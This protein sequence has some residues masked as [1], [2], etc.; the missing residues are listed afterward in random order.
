[1]SNSVQRNTTIIEDFRGM[2]QY[3]TLANP[4]N[5]KFAETGQNFRINKGAVERINSPKKY[6]VVGTPPASD[7]I[8]DFKCKLNGTSYRLIGIG[9]NLYNFDGTNL[10]T[11]YTSL[12]AT[13]LLDFCI[14]N[15]LIIICQDGKKVLQ[16]DGI[17]CQQVSFTDPG[18]IW[19]DARPLCAK[20]HAN[21]LYYFDK[22][23]KC[24][25]PAPG[26]H[27]DFDNT[28]G[29]VD[30]FVIASGMGDQLVGALPYIGEL[31]II[32]FENSVY[33]LK[34]SQPYSNTAADPHIVQLISNEIGC[35]AK[36]T[37]LEVG[38]DHHWISKNGPVTLQA[39]TAYGDVHASELGYGIQDDIKL[40][41]TNAYASKTFSFYEK[42]TGKVYF[43]FRN[44]DG[45]TVR[46]GYDVSRV[47]S[48]LMGKGVIDFEKAVFATTYTLGAYIDNTIWY[49]DNAGNIYNVIDANYT[50]SGFIYETHFFTSKA[51]MQSNKIWKDLFLLVESD[52]T[53]TDL[54]I[55][56]AHIKRGSQL[57][58]YKTEHRSLPVSAVWNQIIWNQFIWNQKS[59][60]IIRIHNC[61]KSEAIKLRIRA[62]NSGEHLRIKRL[63][64]GSVIIGNAKG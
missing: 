24:Y 43:H 17:T 25:T 19:L 13:K 26:T 60:Q 7:I 62:L 44:I 40:F 56:W 59:V 52:T 14:Y 31:L 33:K 11:I 5:F 15:N 34:G 22:Y 18:S 57:D 9:T 47:N 35:I 3:Q 42:T 61:G 20:V 51:A 27:N 2:Y 54:I 12:D 48:M 53:L 46:Y 45:S 41:L 21:R 32:Y 29:T 8:G 58:T 39:V 16:Y 6:T 49:G 50:D 4:K 30:G 55:E 1:M 36:N 28:N 23:N 10:N 63:E 64:L 37:I 38:T